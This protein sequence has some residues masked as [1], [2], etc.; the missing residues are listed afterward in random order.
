MWHPGRSLPHH[1]LKRR[2]M[3]HFEATVRRRV[4]GAVC[5]PRQICLAPAARARSTVVKARRLQPY[6]V[7]GSGH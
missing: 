2:G 6:P 5:S 4:G 3:W 1:D 7:A